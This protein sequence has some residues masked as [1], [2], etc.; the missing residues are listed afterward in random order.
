M[1]LPSSTS[2]GPSVLLHYLLPLT[3]LL[4][5]FLGLASATDGPERGEYPYPRGDNK[6]FYFDQGDEVLLGSIPELITGLD[7]MRGLV[8]ESKETLGSFKEAFLGCLDC[9]EA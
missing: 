2:P 1:S 8:E 4:L 7:S 3:S 5:L 6:I 9:K